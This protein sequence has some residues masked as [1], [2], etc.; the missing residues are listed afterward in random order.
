MTSL[1]T[2]AVACTQG[3]KNARGLLA[4][5]QAT[6]AAGECES[7]YLEMAAELTKQ[8]IHTFETRAVEIDGLLELDPTVQV[9]PIICQPLATLEVL[10]AKIVALSTSNDLW[11]LFKE[12][13]EEEDVKLVDLLMRLGVDPS[14]YKNRAIRMAAE[15][16]NLSVV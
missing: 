16:G 7:R 13:V 4:S 5:I 10:E 6:A 14:A 3:E 2:E 11:Q 1:Y 15:K 8:A 9:L 12:A